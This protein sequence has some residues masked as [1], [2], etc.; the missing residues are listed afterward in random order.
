MSDT[1]DIAKEPM[2]K[3]VSALATEFSRLRTGRASISLLDA[4]RV[5]YFGQQLPLN[6]MATL[7][8]PEPRLITISPWDKNAITPIEKG[9][10]K[11]N[12]GLTPMNDGKIIR[13]PIPALTE[14]RRQEIVKS[15]KKKAEECRISIRQA[16]REA[17][18]LIKQME[19]DGELT[20]DDLK[21]NSTQIQKL[22]DDY[23]QKVDQMVTKKEEEIL[24]V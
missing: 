10:E 21:K 1:I 6:Q 17:I 19:K 8:V 12:L 4:V 2:E 9:I 22:T 13:V 14:E 20:E 24:Q 5:E 16:R 23:V 7:G 18:D 11:A 15:I 3:A